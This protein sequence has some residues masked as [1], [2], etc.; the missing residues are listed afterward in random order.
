MKPR[1]ILLLLVSA[2][3]LIGLAVLSG[4]RREAPAA[5]QSGSP[6][7]PGLELNR[8]AAVEVA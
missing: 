5:S 2:A 1:Q 7:L 6:L 4:K 8:I 3:I